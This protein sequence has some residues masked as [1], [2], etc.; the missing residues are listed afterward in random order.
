M[1]KPD[2]VPEKAE[3]LDFLPWLKDRRLPSAFLPG[4]EQIVP[5]T[6]CPRCKTV[7]PTK[8]LETVTCACGLSMYLESFLFVWADEMKPARKLEVV[9]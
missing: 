7:T 3:A 6:M 5:G 9:R 1:R 4:L 2:G 8:Y